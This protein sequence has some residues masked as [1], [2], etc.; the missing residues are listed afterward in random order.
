MT[1]FGVAD[2][3]QETA[4]DVAASASITL[5]G[6]AAIDLV[7]F[8]FAG[9]NGKVVPYM[10]EHA[11][12]GQWECGEGIYTAPATLARTTVFSN[13][14]GTT[15]LINFN[16]GV[17]NV[18]CDLPSEKSVMYDADSDHVTLRAG[19]SL[20]GALDGVTTLTTSQAITV[21]ATGSVFSAGSDAS[22]DVAIG[23]GGSTPG[24]VRTASLTLAVPDSGSFRGIAK[25]VLK[26][27]ASVIWAVG[28]FSAVAG[29]M[30]A[31]TDYAFDPGTGTPVAALSAAGALKLSAGLTAT[32]G[33]FSTTLAVTGV[34]TLTGGTAATL[35]FGT[36]L[37]GTS[38][39][40]SGNVTIATD[41]AT[42]NTASTLV[43]RDGSGNFAA[44]TITATL[45][46]NASTATILQTARAINGVN[47]DG[48]APITITAAAGTLTG[49]T[50]NATVVTSSLTSVGTL[51][52]LTVSAG[53]DAS[54]TVTL[55]SGGGTPAASRTVSL[56][57]NAPNIAGNKGNAYAQYQL[58]SA[59]QWITGV[60]NTV[61]G[62]MTAVTDYVWQD[63]AG[64]NVVA[65]T[66]AGQVTAASFV[67]TSTTVP[68][69]GIYTSGANTLS[70]AVNSL[71]NFQTN[72]VAV[73]FY[74][75]T[76]FYVYG[77]AND[78][79]FNLAQKQG[80]VGSANYMTFNFVNT[81]GNTVISLN[82]YGPTGTAANGG[83]LFLNAARYEMQTGYL[84]LD[85][86]G[87]ISGTDNT[88]DIGASGASRFR[89]L[90]L[91]RN[92]V[93]GGALTVSAMVTTAGYTASS[94]SKTFAN[95]PYAV[96][97]TDEVI[98]YDTSGGA[99]QVTLPASPVNGRRV[100]VK[101]ITT[102]GNA[103]TISRNG[104]NI[105]G[106]AADVVTSSAGRPSYT[107]EYDSTAGSWW[108][109]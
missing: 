10:I 44:G 9:L 108:I 58:A 70:F 78:V 19:L 5:L 52:G 83:V 8:A 106:S 45:T 36:H 77:A 46:G 11:S 1:I 84:Q 95:T 61:A 103:L 89:D 104:K 37:T 96:S 21:N 15:A 66:Q 2:R 105:E 3:V 43:A 14:L 85:A 29:A 93:I 53:T 39:N 71:L 94:V 47:F 55:G 64:T 32:S 63:T 68:T 102:D 88:Y 18:W 92:A 67:P 69:L 38:Y 86:G 97:A 41:A 4:R 24:A 82:G 57:L 49:T 25:M 16:A 34:S 74:K 80:S 54:T 87:I 90:F 91:G 59:T 60:L 50:L 13:S 7:T 72:T 65:I 99:S 31:N 62:A 30:G 75:A 109:I 101:K 12:S 81:D 35:T 26:R 79:T 100:N 27:A 73:N 17:V 28:I 42:A 22:T 56:V 23:S 6:A 20:V 107:L 33:V 48:S 40:S 51:T 98:L 76:N